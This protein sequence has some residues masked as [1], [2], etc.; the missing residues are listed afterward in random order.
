M[1]IDEQTSE[2]NGKMTRFPVI[3][4]L[5]VIASFALLGTVSAGVFLGWHSNAEEIRVA[6]AVLGA[7]TGIGFKVAHIL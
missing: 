1:R 3:H 2:E 6:G 4:S 5:R 7:L